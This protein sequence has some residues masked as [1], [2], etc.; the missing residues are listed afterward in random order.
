MG[1][2][3]FDL[4]FCNCPKPRHQTPDRW[5]ALALLLEGVAE[6]LASPSG[7]PPSQQAASVAFGQQA[8]AAR[9]KLLFSALTSVSRSWSL[10]FISGS[11][12][13]PGL[14]HLLIYRLTH[15]SL[16]LYGCLPLPGHPH[17]PSTSSLF[18]SKHAHTC[19]APG[20]LALSTWSC[21]LLA[22][23]PLLWTSD[24]WSFLVPQFI[25]WL[26]NT[27]SFNI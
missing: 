25:L 26:L 1:C 6:A 24:E 16:L 9:L 18:I 17:R 4:S 27:H 11:P 14:L 2:R 19:G 22:S 8:P 5:L 13:R 12:T 23:Q 7:P 15:S 10:P 20:H 21:R 3:P